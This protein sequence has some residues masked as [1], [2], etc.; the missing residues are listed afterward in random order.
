M[1]KEEIV[2]LKY[3]DILEKIEPQECHLLLGNGFNRGLGVDTSYKSIFKKMTENDHGI[4]KDAKTIVAECGDDLEKFIGKLVDDIADQNSFLKK[5]VANKVKCDFM[6]AAHEIVKSGIKN[7]YAERNEG[8]YILLKNFANYFT[9]NYDSFLYLL[10]LNFKLADSNPKKTIAMQPSLKFVEKDMNDVQNNIYSEIKEARRG[11]SININFWQK[12]NVVSKDMWDLTKKNF[13]S[14]IEIY[15]K[16]NNKNWK[17]SDIERV[18]K[19]I[20]EEE[21]KNNILKNIDDGSIISLFNNSKEF[22]F[23]VSKETQNLFFLH[24]AFHIYRDWKEEKKIT[25]STD[26]A[27]YDK[28]EEI[29]NNE[30]RDIICIFQ[31]E[32]KIDE[33]NRSKYLKKCYDKLSELS[34]AMVIIGCSLSDNDQHIFTQINSSKIN[35]LYISTRK[36][37]AEENYKKAK[38]YFQNKEII[39]F[40]AES[41]SYELPQDTD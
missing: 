12:S 6:K 3:K 24:W 8:I 5:Y 38:K 9:L 11:W 21:K 2:L 28:L 7:I 27:L 34:G 25:Q 17:T 18:V 36:E 26:G 33:I 15:S 14:G 1:R 13:I 30:E 4:Y 35:T 19:S 32:N 31:S 41:I 39:L 22:V 20:L 40:E 29:L 16:S 37:N 10:L 23:D